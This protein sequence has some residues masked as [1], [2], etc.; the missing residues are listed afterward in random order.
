MS[1]NLRQLANQ[2][3]ELFVSHPDIHGLAKMTG[4]TKERNG[5]QEAVC[6]TIKQPIQINDWIT[7][8]SG[9]NPSLGCFP[10][11]PDGTVRWAALDIDVYQDPG[12]LDRIVTKVKEAN[13]P[14]IPCRS[15]SS[16]AHLYLF[17]SE[18]VPATLV[19]R[20]LKAL[21]A[22]LGQGT[23]EIYPKQESIGTQ[24]NDAR[25]GNWLNMPYS[26]RLRYALNLDEQTES[27]YPALSIEE[28]LAKANSYALTLGDLESLEVPQLQHTALPDG[29]PCLNYILENGLLVDGRRNDVLFQIGIYYKKADPENVEARLIEIAERYTSESDPLDQ[30]EVRNIAKSVQKKDYKHACSK[31]PMVNHCNR[32]ICSKCK[33]GVHSSN[34]LL[35]NRTLTMVETD[36][37]IW[38]LTL[39]TDSGPKT[40][41]FN[42]DQISSNA[43]FN[44]RVMETIREVLPP[45]EPEVWF[46]IKKNLMKSC[47]VVEIPEEATPVGQLRAALSEFA[48]GAT[49]NTESIVTAGRAINTDTQEF[50]FRL[51]VFQE[52]LDRT[53]FK[54]M[55]P[56]EII[57]ALKNSFKG[58]VHRPTINSGRVRFWAIPIANLYEPT[59]PTDIRIPESVI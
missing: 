49:E 31:H 6:W 12:L 7:H 47:Q 15:K 42:T 22:Y 1:D 30:K 54:A 24:E 48:N 52:Y 2:M 16:G 59:Q 37:P 27:G 20:K 18:S 8:L 10:L 56:N 32:D 11:R 23:S 45:E 41:S 21:S 57:A 58:Q 36:P 39:D 38:Y 43:L 9:R 50:C 55:K 17:F 26:G 29:P 3:S 13:L 51:Q 34:L 40:I 44:K 25:Y 33:F 19:I 28:F 46:E 14:L 53:R 4:I 35:G 5:K